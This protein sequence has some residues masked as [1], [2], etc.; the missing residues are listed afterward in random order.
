LRPGERVEIQDAREMGDRA[1]VVTLLH[2]GAGAIK[3]GLR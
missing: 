1:Q 3:V 2:I